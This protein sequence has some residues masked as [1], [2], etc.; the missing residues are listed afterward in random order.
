M[1]LIRLKLLSEFRGLAKDFEIEFTNNKI[2]PKSIDPICLI[3]LNGSGKSNVLEVIS[4]IFYYLETF[5]SANKNDLKKYNY[6]FGFEIEYILPRSVY[7]EQINT[8]G[9]RNLISD[10]NYQ[11]RIYKECNKTPFLRILSNDELLFIDDIE[12]VQDALSLPSQIIG[13]SS[14]MNELISNPYIK[15]DFQYLDDFDKFAKDKADLFDYIE[16]NR[17][18]FMDYDA[19]KLITICNFLFDMSFKGDNENA[20]MG[21]INLSTVKEELKLE[22]LYSFSLSIKLKDNNSRSIKIPSFLNLAI[23]N[24]KKCSTVFDEIKIENKEP[25]TVYEFYFY[26]NNITKELFKDYFK[27]AREL[28]KTFYYLRLLN[29]YLIG[30]DTQYKI[31]NFKENINISALL[32]KY[33]ES[34]KVFNISDI[35]FKKNKIIKP[36]YY[37]QLSDGEHQ[38]LHV[39]GTLLLM[40]KLGTL[41]LF[42]EPETHFNPEWRSKFVSIINDVLFDENT[43]RE[44]ELILTTH[45][46]FIVS[47]CQ[48]ENVYIFEKD[49]NLKVRKVKNPEFQT[50][51]TSIEMIYW[52]VFQKQQSISNVAKNE[53]D[54]IETKIKSNELNKEQAIDALRKFGDSFEKMNI[55]KLLREKYK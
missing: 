42:D 26:V 12:L 54:K 48:K 9:D 41:F 1:K 45:S 3:G 46:P 32:P 11:M 30:R 2:N 15:M 4:E 5:K 37:K 24:L 17:L 7:L 10:D 33:E 39:I 13:Y 34:K 14:G 35:S 19:N 8:T 47:D 22:K 49:S 25:Y 23:E 29:N 50:F 52:N 6:E 55:I 38:F 44:Q 16:D 18:F 21:I 40:D 20:Q 28:F 51:G 53:L 27:S 43:S 31:K 36:V